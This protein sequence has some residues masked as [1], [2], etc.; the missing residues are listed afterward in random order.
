M[1]SL[2]I[3]CRESKAKKN[4]LAPLVVRI[5]VK[6]KHAYVY[7][8]KSLEPKL[9]DKD[10]ERVKKSH[11]NSKRL[12][13]ILANV[14]NKIEGIMY[15]FELAEKFYSAAMVKDK[16]TEKNNGKLIE[17]AESWAEKRKN[18]K[19]RSNMSDCLFYLQVLVV[20][21]SMSTHC[22]GGGCHFS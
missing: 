5:T 6:R 3:L 12:N 16:F 19:A 17:Y 14:K 21:V 8:N 7:L 1:S 13:L 11:P 18:E 9:W 4:G 20:A 15:D 10:R 2:K 22:C